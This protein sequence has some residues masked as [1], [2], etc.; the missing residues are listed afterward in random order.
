MTAFSAT[1][2]RAA[3]LSVSLATAFTGAALAQDTAAPHQLP[4]VKV[5]ASSA[6]AA[7]AQGAKTDLPLRELPQAVQVVT[8]EAIDDLRATR[9]DD[10]T[11]HVSGVSR[12]NSFGGLWD[13]VAI[14]GLAGN[15]NTGPTMLLNGFSANR[16]YNAPRDLAGVDRIEFLKGPAAA[17]YGSSEPGGTLNVVSKRPLW[18]AQ[19]D[20]SV[21]F[22]SF[23]YKRASID[24]TGPLGET[25]AVRVNAAMVDSESFRDHVT[26]K[27]EVLAPAF[28]WRLGADTVLDY[29]GELLRHRTPLDRGVVAVDNRLGAIPVSRFFG[30]PADGDITVTNR[31]HQLLLSHEWSPT[32]RSRVGLSYRDTSMVGYATEASALQADGQLWRQ[33]RYRDFA[34]DDL[35]LQ[36]EVQGRVTTGGLDHDLL[37]GLETYRFTLDSR[38]LRINP[39]AAAPYAIDIY[40]P[41]YGQAQPTPGPNTDTRETQRNT[42]L[43]VQD[44]LTLAPAWRLLGGLRFDHFEQSLDNHR[45]GTTASQS[46]DAASP[47]LG[48]SWVPDAAWTVYANAGRSFRPNVASEGQAF[49]P[50]TGRALELGV[51]WQSADGRVGA[52]AALFDVRKR[53]VLTSVSTSVGTVQVAAGEVSSR[54]VEF[55]VSGALSSRVR[56]QANATFLDSEITRDGTLEVGS[57]LLNVPRTSAGL[58]ALYEAAAPVGQRYGVGAGVTYVGTRLGQARTNADVTSGAPTFELPAYTTVKL[59]THWQMTSTWRATLTVDNL[60]DTTYYTSSY[61]RL[62]VAPGTERAATLGLQ[63]RF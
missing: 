43:Y 23:G 1:A 10:V 13:N 57:R 2:R 21:E 16:G 5:S 56:L 14:R 59:L 27:R 26:T 58:L 60:F 36:A 7:D 53:N 45:T 18:A 41:V 32:W 3:P 49:D 39:S 51:K 52:S 40:N 48:I 24:A 46:P 50:E 54:G 25:F 17:L 35:A 30:E 11:D 9:L 6:G 29:T 15:E 28:T 63:A 31:T 22:G 20:A 44:A 34:S 12:Q 55:D 37:V 62:W 61:S 47:R 42:A 38:M 8:R 4:A 19:N 33:R